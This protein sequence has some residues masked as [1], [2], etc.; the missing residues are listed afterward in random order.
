MLQTRWSILPEDHRNGIKTFITNLVIEMSKDEN[1]SILQGH[2]YLSKLNSVLV[3]IV[4]HECTT[5]WQEFI[6][7]I[8]EGSQGHQGVCE[9]SLYILKLLSEEIFDFSKEELTS[10]KAQNLKTAM[11]E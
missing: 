7:E 1:T 10:E 5:T 2:P 3:A 6:P 8:C 11:T 9:N 4:K